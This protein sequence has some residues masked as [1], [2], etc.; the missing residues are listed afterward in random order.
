MLAVDA[1]FEPFF[2]PDGTADRGGYGL[3][4]AIAKRAVKAHGGWIRAANRPGGGLC[5]EITLPRG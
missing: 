2:H 3:G 1:V 4:L 5:V